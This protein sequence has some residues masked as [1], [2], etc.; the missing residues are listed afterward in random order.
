MSTG[1]HGLSCRLLKL[2]EM[3]G[4][5]KQ[6]TSARLPTP[7]L[8]VKQRTRADIFL[9]IPEHRFIISSYETDKLKSK[10]PMEV[11]LPHYHGHAP[12][13]NFTTDNVMCTVTTVLRKRKPCQPCVKHLQLFNAV[14]S[15]LTQILPGKE[16]K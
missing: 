3:M 10:P 8:V 13:M 15:E 2:G 5:D 6:S 16:R 1:K 4:G 11:P 12:Y 7:L 9:P 14:F